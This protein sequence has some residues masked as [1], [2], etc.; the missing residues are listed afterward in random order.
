VINYYVTEFIIVPEVNKEHNIHFLLMI[1][2]CVTQFIIEPEVNKEH[3]IQI[4]NTVKP[5]FNGTWIKRKPVH[6][7]HLRWISHTYSVSVT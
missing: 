7:Q 1:H 2:Y 3:N 6:Y 5:I 4:K